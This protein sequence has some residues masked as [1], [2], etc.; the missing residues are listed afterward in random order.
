MKTTTTKPDQ[1]AS[2]PCFECEAGTLQPILED[3]VTRHPKLE[4]VVIP[5]VPMLRCDECGDVVIGQE[6]NA[7][8]DAWLDAALNAISPEDIRA[9]LT[10]YNLTQRRASQITGLG[11]KNISRWLTGRARPSESVSNFLRLLLADEDSFERLK[12]KNFTE[13]E[14]G[15]FSA[16]PATSEPRR[17]RSCR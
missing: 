5:D 7:R 12:Q 1:H 17:S 8:I 4:E 9:L 13:H 14:P 3:H 2:I 16:P 10:K 11:E 6:G 15:L